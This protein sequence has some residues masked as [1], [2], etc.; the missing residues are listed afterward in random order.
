MSGTLSELPLSNSLALLPFLNCYSNS[1]FSQTEL[2]S[3]FSLTPHHINGNCYIPTFH[4]YN[5]I[6][7]ISNAINTENIGIIATVSE[8]YLD[9]PPVIKESILKSV[10]LFDIFFFVSSNQSLLGSHLNIWLEHEKDTFYICHQRTAPL[11]IQGLSQGEYHRTLT[12]INVLRR[13]LGD[14][15]K[16]EALYLASRLAPPHDI[17]TMTRSGKVF[18]N[19]KYGRIPIKT[20]LDKIAESVSIGQLTSP[21]DY[22]SLDRL[23]VA[24]NTFI[25]HEDLDLFFLSDIFG[26]SKRSI[27]RI[28]KF[29]GTTFKNIIAQQ[30]T[31]HAITLLN[32]EI[33]IIHIA[34]RLGYSDPSN[35][36]RAFKRHTGLSPSS[37]RRS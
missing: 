10:S 30:K 11:K 21:L 32:E 4:I 26:C 13:F 12:I 37:F 29:H 16:P 2:L 24:I 18:T 28:L 22:S 19:V 1:D 36:T 33:S 14:D 5:I 3:N 8:D 35:F 23:R 20:S 15:W 34:Q 25:E 31:A 27:Q 9:L 17:I 7:E 6:N